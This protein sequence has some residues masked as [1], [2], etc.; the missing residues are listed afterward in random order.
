MLP[1]AV[2]DQEHVQIR[3]VTAD[4]AGHDEWVGIDGIAVIGDDLVV[5]PAAKTDADSRPV[6]PVKRL[7]SPKDTGN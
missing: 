1:A 3:W 7:R 2:N 5:A 4:A 6:K